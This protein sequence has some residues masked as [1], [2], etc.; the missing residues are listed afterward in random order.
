MKKFKTQEEILNF[1]RSSI[2]KSMVHSV[3][4]IPY[5]SQIRLFF[6]KIKIFFDLVIILY[7]EK[8]RKTILT[9]TIPRWTKEGFKYSIKPVMPVNYITITTKLKGDEGDET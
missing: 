2:E 6:Y 1:I 8:R 7:K 3:F 4:E 5:K 9:F